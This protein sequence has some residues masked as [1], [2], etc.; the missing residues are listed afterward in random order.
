VRAPDIG[1][2][3]PRTRS[4][5]SLRGPL[6]L[7]VAVAF[8]ALVLAYLL[9]TRGS[10]EFQIFLIWALA[11]TA[12]AVALVIKY[13]ASHKAVWAVLAAGLMV[14][15]LGSTARYEVI[16]RAYD[17]SADAGPYYHKGV[18]IAEG[19]WHLD[20]TPLFDATGPTLGTRFLTQV[21]GVV[22]SISGPSMRGAFVVFSL[23]AFA[24]VLFFARAYARVPGA[25]PVAY[26]AW[27]VF[28][29]SLFFW[30][31]SIGKEAFLLFALGL[32]VWGYARFP[33]PAAWVALA[34]GLLLVGMVRPHVAG[35][36]MAAMAVGVIMARTQGR[37]VGRW[38]F[39]A[40]FFAAALVLTFYLSAGALGIESAES[41]VELVEQ[42]AEKSNTGGSA[43]GGISV[44]P[45]QIPNAFVRALFRPFIWE[46]SSAF[47][48]ISALEVILMV[49][50]II[51]RRKQLWASLRGWRR[52]RLIAFSLVFVVL[53]SLMLGF[54][55]SNL[56][57]IARQRTLMLPMLLLLLQG[58]SDETAEA[59]KET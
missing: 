41:A 23:L 29:P 36:A 5:G 19:I 12:V 52:N 32:A 54:S 22:V 55:M 11:V 45:L 21:S 16:Q 10:S 31:S 56:A 14:K 58:F 33:R 42:Q 2:L 44:S 6:L 20:L 35:V 26:L 59:S 4:L 49:L 13:D 51:W 27:L 8:G 25:R 40:V 47:I 48:L 9:A 37:V 28:W 7:F 30:P 46:A 3:L 57:I 17:G 38:Y 53:Y 43:V 34:G 50:L 39:Q 1:A 15:L 18:A 24:G